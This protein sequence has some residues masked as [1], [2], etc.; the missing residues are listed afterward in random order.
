MFRFAQHDGEEKNR[1]TRERI[2]R[3]EYSQFMALA[4]PS[5]LS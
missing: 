5:L 1:R 4:Q 3:F 2:R